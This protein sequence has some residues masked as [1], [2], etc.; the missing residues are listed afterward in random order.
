MITST[1]AV[2]KVRNLLSLRPST[3]AG[4]F[5]GVFWVVVGALISQGLGMVASV[6]VARYWER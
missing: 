2:L 3:E 5:G 1:E 4:F 6:M